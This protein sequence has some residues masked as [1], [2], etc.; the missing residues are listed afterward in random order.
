MS[1]LH[2][3]YA[4]ALFELAVEKGELDSTEAV[5][6][7]L[8]EGFAGK[9]AF[10]SHPNVADDTVRKMVAEATDSSLMRHFV[11]VIM[12]HGRLGELTGILDA[13]FTVIQ[14]LSEE[15]EIHIYTAHALSAPQEKKL[16]EAFKSRFKS[17]TLTVHVDPQMVGGLR[18]AYDDKIF[19]AST[20][21]MYDTLKHTISR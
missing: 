13:F 14:A 3:S 18:I 6:H 11:D 17:P 1:S 8:A 19:D 15:K 9:K 16:V 10:L 2:R 7:G 20:S 4:Q 5:A 21:T 12:H